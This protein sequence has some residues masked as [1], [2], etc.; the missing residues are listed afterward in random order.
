MFCLYISP[1]YVAKINTEIH[2]HVSFQKNKNMVLAGCRSGVV[3]LFDIR[4]VP[5]G[6]APD[7]LGS[8]F[9]KKGKSSVVHLQ[10]VRDW[11]LLVSTIAG[12]VCPSIFV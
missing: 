3:N 4:A 6:R 8:R 7:L 1:R 5:K 9:E 2:S 10:D 12:D 11:Q